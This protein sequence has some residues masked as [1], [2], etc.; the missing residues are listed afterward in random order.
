MLLMLFFILAA[1]LIGS[2]PFGLLVG[3]VRGVDIRTQGSGNI[4]ATNA[5]RVLG[6]PYGIAVFLLDVLKGLL[7]TLLFGFYVQ[8]LWTTEPPVG[9]AAIFLW[10]I[11]AGAA[12]I[13]GH[14]FPIYLGFRGGKGVATSL[15]VLLG[16]YPWLTWPGLIGFGVWGVLTGL[17]RYVSVGSVGAAA[18]FPIIFAMMVHWTGADDRGFDFQRLWP[19]YGFSVAMAVLVIFRHRGNLKRLMAGTESKLGSSDKPVAS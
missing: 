10:W 8:G 17:T 5:G 12:C 9:G 19:L 1:Y 14:I 2:I 7:P 13:C 4:G 3:L 11:T 15:G 16:F 18:A 6:K